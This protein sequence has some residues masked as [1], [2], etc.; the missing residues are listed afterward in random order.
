MSKADTN[1]KDNTEDV[2][3]DAKSLLS[4]MKEREDVLELDVGGEVEQLPYRHLSRS[5]IRRIWLSPG[6]ELPNK[7]DYKVE[8]NFDPEN[9]E[10]L[11]DVANANELRN[12]AVAAEMLITGGSEEYFA[13][14]VNLPHGKRAAYLH[15]L[16]LP[17]MNALISIVM[18][19]G[20]MALDEVARARR[21]QRG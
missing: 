4:R 1:G 8:G 3:I 20:S 2:K 21:F 13:E 12:L 17:Y 19:T 6:L 14:L 18:T 5:K 10:W 9:P 15:N 11:E 7:D 16:P